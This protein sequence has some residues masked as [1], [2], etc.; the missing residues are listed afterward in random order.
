MRNIGLP[1]WIRAAV[2]VITFFPQRSATHSRTYWPAVKKNEV[3]LISP[4]MIFLFKMLQH[5]WQ[6]FKYEL[7]FSFLFL[8]H[9]HWFPCV[10]VCLLVS[11]N[12]LNRQVGIEKALGFGLRFKCRFLF[13]Q[14]VWAD[15][16]LCWGQDFVVGHRT[17][18]FT[19]A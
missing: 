5:N 3:N 16:I 4:V 19:R 9:T 2:E 10:C 15:E 7:L 18:F 13:R 12:L 14:I 6:G 11:F 8:V 17:G 1:S